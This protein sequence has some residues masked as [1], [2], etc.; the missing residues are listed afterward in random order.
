[1]AKLGTQII[2][3]KGLDSRVSKFVKDPKSA[4]VAENFLVRTETR[5]TRPELTRYL[6]DKNF[7]NCVRLRSRN[8]NF[9]I[10][11]NPD[12][13]KFPIFQTNGTIECKVRLHG[14]EGY[15]TEQT[16]PLVSKRVYTSGVGSSTTGYVRVS[17]EIASATSNSEY[18]VRFEVLDGFNSFNVVNT[19][20]VI[21]YN[22]WANISC[23]SDGSEATININGAITNFAI[24]STGAGG[25]AFIHDSNNPIH[26]DILIGAN[27]AFSEFADIDI[28]EIR[29]WNGKRSD[30][31]QTA[32]QGVELPTSELD[33]TTLKFYLNFEEDSDTPEVYTDKKNSNVSVFGGT[34]LPFKDSSDRLVLDGTT[35]YGEL[36]NTDLS[37]HTLDTVTVEWRGVLLK[38]AAGFI[39]PNVELYPGTSKWT[40]RY[41]YRDNSIATTLDTA[42]LIDQ[43]DFG[44]TTYSIGIR[45]DNVSGTETAKI[46]VDGVEKAT[47]NLAGVWTNIIT[48]TGKNIGINDTLNGEYVAQKIEFVRGI[49]T[50]KDVT[51]MQTQYASAPL[52][53]DVGQYMHEHLDVTEA[54]STLVASNTGTRAW[55]A[56][57]PPST[58][59]AISRNDILEGVPGYEYNTVLTI[60]GSGSGSIPFITGHPVTAADADKVW[61]FEGFASTNLVANYDIGAFKQIFKDLDDAGISKAPNNSLVSGGFTRGLPNLRMQLRSRIPTAAIT[62]D[63]ARLPVRIGGTTRLEEQSYQKVR[64]LAPYVDSDNNI[65]VLIGIVGTALFSIDRVTT[66]I[67]RHYANI[68][69]NGYKLFSF[70]YLN[71]ELYLTD[72]KT[73]LHVLTYKGELK[74]VWWGI[75]PPQALPVATANTSTGGI[76]VAM[77]VVQY[78][79]MYYNRFTDQYSSMCPLNVNGTGDE[80]TLTPRA[81]TTLASL[82]DNIDPFIEG[83]DIVILGTRTKASAPDPTDWRILNFIDARTIEARDWIQDTDYDAATRIPFKFVGFSGNDFSPPDGDVVITHRSRMWIFKDSNIHFSDIMAGPLYAIVKLTT[84]IFPSD[85]FITLPVQSKLTAGISIDGVLYAFTCT[86]LTALVGSDPSNFEVRDVHSGAGCVSHHTL[87]KVGRSFMWMGQDDIYELKNGVPSSVDGEG[88][89]TEFIRDHVDLSKA[90][91]FFAVVNTSENLYELHV[92][93]NTTSPNVGERVVIYWDLRAREFTIATDVNSSFSVSID[94]GC[95]NK[96]YHGHEF[97]FITKA[98]GDQNYQPPSGSLSGTVSV[99]SVGGVDSVSRPRI[100]TNES[101][102]YTTDGG[103]VGNTLYIVDGGATNIVRFKILSNTAQDIIVDGDTA[104]FMMGSLFVPGGG[105]SYYIGSIFW[106]YM[107]GLLSSG[108]QNPILQKQQLKSEG[109]IFSDMVAQELIQLE[110]VHD[111]ITDNSAR[112]FGQITR[113]H[114]SA[115]APFEFDVAQ[116]EEFTSLKSFAV[117]SRYRFLQLHF[118]YLA[119]TS[120]LD[121]IGVLLT[122]QASKDGTIG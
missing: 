86:G 98:G 74:I 17:L 3:A 97:G 70:D 62:V 31:D 51:Y 29:A 49:N 116:N 66:A 112:L 88:K 47:V 34:C 37:A 76:N 32:Y 109:A 53:S 40:L 21:K 107:S 110:A 91:E 92:Q 5:K 95:E 16:I 48:S 78:A 41:H 30:A 20:P 119:E 28:D 85:N 65:D 27:D 14:E 54:G 99:F 61:S 105:N 58:I 79:Y 36:I 8:K 83:T 69:P 80:V 22:E 26:D 101:D 39:F 10:A 38:A 11:K 56:S 114:N 67:T 111:S 9:I 45:V 18:V 84:H 122:Q 68:E 2:G 24:T 89:I 102:L 23:S 12:S 44:V 43:A 73:K 87:K 46:F 90:S 63:R 55:H 59:L 104:R 7:S 75:R 42:D 13:T 103:L 121:F 60:L 113:D 94:E 120:P 64:F 19:T 106:R 57:L 108:S 50:V 117:M 93:L 4:D 81:Y 115:D 96:V 52:P 82:H 118:A 1:M 33:K 25:G 35:N 72:G 6:Y 77:G 100:T 71:G 15:S